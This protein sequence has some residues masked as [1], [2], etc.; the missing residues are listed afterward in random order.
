MSIQS[1]KD[2]KDLK[3]CGERLKRQG[4]SERVFTL[5]DEFN[6]PENRSYK[7]AMVLAGRLKAIAQAAT[8]DSYWD[9][10]MSA[11]FQFEK[12]DLEHCS[13]IGTLPERDESWWIK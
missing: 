3:K 5:V 2:W 7:N 12:Q 11:G 8:F 13:P 9:E 10:K 6:K 1:L 4:L